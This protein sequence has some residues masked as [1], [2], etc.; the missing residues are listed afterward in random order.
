[1]SATFSKSVSRTSGPM[2]HLL[3]V[4]MVSWAMDSCRETVLDAP[5]SEPQCLAKNAS[6]SSSIMPTYS[7]RALPLSAALMKASWS[8]IIL[9]GA[10]YTMPLPNTGVMNLYT[11]LWLT[12]RSSVE[13]KR[14]CADGPSRKVRF[15][16]NTL[17]VKTGPFSL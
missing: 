14:S 6:L 2:R 11:S 1:M 8:D 5:A 9:G 15:C 16:P 3:A 13:K 7:I 4:R 10:S 17:S 12:H